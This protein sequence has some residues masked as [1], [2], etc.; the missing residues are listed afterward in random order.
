MEL[1]KEIISHN[2]I[3]INGDRAEV[4]PVALRPR[5]LSTAGGH[6]KFALVVIATAQLMVML[7]LTIVN[8]A[9]PAIQKGLGFSTTGLSWVVDAYVLAFGGLLLLGGRSG[10][11]FGRRKMLIIGISLF[12]VA[13]MAGGLADTQVLLIVARVIQGIGAA[14]ASPT[15]LS[16]VATTF[17]EGHERHRAMAVYGAMSGAGGALGLLLGGAL[18][19]I[20]SWRWILFVNVPIGI[21]LIVSA[22]LVLPQGKSVGSGKLDYLGAAL[23][24]SGLAVL[25]FAIERAPSDGWGSS[26]TISLVLLSAALITLFLIREHYIGYAIVPIKFLY[27]KNRAAGFTI[28]ALL[29][30]AMLSILYFLTQFLQNVLHYSP[31]IAGV[32]YVPIPIVVALSS[33]F[34]SKKVAKV[35]IR[36]FL[37]IGPLLLAAGF[38]TA[39]TFSATSGYWKIFL[40]LV[41]VGLGMGLSFVP[42]TLN[43]VSSV[44][45]K[46]SGLAS[47]LLNTSQQLGGSIGLAVMV[48]VAATAVSSR[49]AHLPTLVG[50]YGNTIELAKEKAILMTNAQVQAFHDIMHLG[51]LMALLAF[52][53]ALFLQKPKMVVPAPTI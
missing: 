50:S 19:D 3:E 10:D 49:I 6:K 28:M 31:I 23:A 32:A 33:L 45:Q 20:A 26:L 51:M 40:A 52:G 9:L 22:R 27:H 7:D 18:V 41:L 30:A 24:S 44:I 16:L 25:V 53:A 39:S 21:F 29:G 36:L 37:R 2:D 5:R 14:I 13:S 34:V 12:S 46:E 17:E 8:I 1:A 47:G 4:Q 43:A 11:I 42:L 15:A 48:T 38:L 35:G